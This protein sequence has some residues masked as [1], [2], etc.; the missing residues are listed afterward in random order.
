MEQSR[1]QM[2]NAADIAELTG[3]DELAKI[4]LTNTMQFKVSHT[5]LASP[6]PL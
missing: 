6:P 2:T 1:Q 5:G 4:D 3:V